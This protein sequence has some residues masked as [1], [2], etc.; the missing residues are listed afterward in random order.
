[1]AEALSRLQL[2][3]AEILAVGR[4]RCREGAVALLQGELIIRGIREIGERRILDRL[5]T[6]TRIRRVDVDRR[7]DAC[8][9]RRPGSGPCRA[10]GDAEKVRELLIG[11]RAD[12]VVAGEGLRRFVLRRDLGRQRGLV[13]RDLLPGRD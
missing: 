5:A 4:E 10:V 6:W 9:R 2:R 12:L 11:T 8:G 1:M 3:A 13:L 7:D